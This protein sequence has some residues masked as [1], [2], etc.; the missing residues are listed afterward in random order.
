MVDVAVL[1][2]LVVGLVLSQPLKLPSTNSTT[3]TFREWIVS[4]QVLRLPSTIKPIEHSMLL[5]VVAAIVWSNVWTNSLRA[6]DTDAHVPSPVLVSKPKKTSFPS[7]WQV[8]LPFVDNALSAVASHA[9]ST[10]FSRAASAA[11]RPFVVSPMMV[12]PYFSIHC[13]APY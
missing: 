6:S 12:S 5:L 8:N 11:H 7:S 9:S 3:S 4:V 2:T 1:V 10:V 13:N